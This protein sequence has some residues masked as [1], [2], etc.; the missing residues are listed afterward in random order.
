M[1]NG[2]DLSS[3]GV[4]EAERA[5][6]FPWKMKEWL[7]RHRE[8]AVLVAPMA[9]Y[10]PL[11][12]ILGIRHK[13]NL[14]G[15]AVCYVRRALYLSQGE[16]YYSISGYWSPLISWCMTPL[17]YFG[18][19]GLYAARVVLCVWGAL[20]I[21]VAG[22]LLRAMTTWDAWWRLGVMV[23][24]ALGTASVAAG[25]VTPD[26]L[27][28][29]GLVAY[30]AAIMSADLMERRGAQWLV[31]VLG[32]VAYLGKAYALPFVVVHLP[33]TLALRGWVMWRGGN[34]PTA[35]AR[36]FGAVCRRVF[37]AY[38]MAMLGLAVTAGVW[39]GVLSWRYGR[40][41][42]S[43]A[44]ARAHAVVGPYRPAREIPVLTPPEGPYLVGWENPE[45]LRYKFWS[46]FENRRCFNRQLYVIGKNAREM[47]QTIGGLAFGYLAW[48]GIA[49]CPLALFGLVGRGQRWKV[50][51]LVGT[52]AVY[53]SG[54]VPVFYSPRYIVDVMFVLTLVLCMA[55][56]M[57]FGG[58]RL[59]E[60]RAVAACVVLALFA[61]GGIRQMVVMFN[62]SRPGVYRQLAQEIR[63]MGLK[64]PMVSTDLYKGYCLSLQLGEK[65]LWFPPGTDADLAEQR[66]REHKAG[67]MVVW[68]ERKGQVGMVNE[69]AK[70]AEHLQWK[71]VLA[72]KRGGVEV[73]APATQ[74][75]R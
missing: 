12:I 60:A 56:A 11:A 64:G 16:F 23:V 7:G 65:M 5:P 10:V 13:E 46:P 26:I 30:L 21:V 63:R 34:G 35:E 66:I 52:M 59:G 31:G 47:R 6:P 29:T 43:T 41:T 38:G 44:G 8:A 51:W 73:L 42:F 4:R 67:V 36:A 24:V 61:A 25:H 68:R 18:M 48:V 27:M 69:A 28:A 72:W 32:G 14:L 58:S 39:V 20:F 71:R 15:D 62:T 74:P 50:L 1:E 53:C 40:F 17:V 45:T 70:V 49:L 75:A 2:A 22:F 9:V 54:F 57:G 33:V 3:P 19:D 37:N 55:L